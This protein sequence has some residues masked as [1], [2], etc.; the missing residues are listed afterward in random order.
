[1]HSP[2][3]DRERSRRLARAT[4]LARRVS[5]PNV[6][7]LTQEPPA[8][9][10]L[11]ERIRRHGPLS[12]DEARKLA[13]Q[14]CAGLA[15]AH[16]RG[17]AHGKLSVDSIR[18]TDGVAVITDLGMEQ[19]RRGRIDEREDVYALGA[20]LYEALTGEPPFS[21]PVEALPAAV[22]APILRCLQRDPRRRYGTV[23]EAASAL[24][25][26]LAPSQ[27]S[28]AP[29]RG[30]ALAGTLALALLGV[31]AYA[32]WSRS[33]PGLPAARPG[34]EVTATLR[35]REERIVVALAGFD[36][37]ALPP[38]R[39]WIARG[40]EEW[41]AAALLATPSVEP[42]RGTLDRA[43][44]AA[45]ARRAGVDV[46]VDGA[47]APR[48]GGEGG[49][50]LEL[51]LLDVG[52]GALRLAE[53]V[54]IAGEGDL[55]K[56]ARALYEK[57]SRAIR[58]P[59]ASSATVP[60]TGMT[61]DIAALRAYAEARM[62]EERGDLAAAERGLRAA[63]AADPA[64][65]R[66]RAS[67][68]D[69]LRAVG[70][71]EEA[72]RLAEESRSFAASAGE[73]G[74]LTIARLTARS[75][76]ARVR[77]LEALAAR[78][79]RETA[80]ARELVAAL[81]E[82]GR[83]ADC[84]V[85]A[86]RAFEANPAASWALAEAARCSLDVG[87]VDAALGYARRLLS[88]RQ[89]ESRAN[90][91]R[92]GRSEVP[93][94]IFL[95]LGR[96]GDAYDLLRRDADAGDALASARLALVALH[97]RGRC[98]AALGLLRKASARVVDRPSAEWLARA[99]SFAATSCAD[100]GE[101]R[102]AEAWLRRVA[103]MSPV[104]AELAL[105]AA[106]ARGERG[107]FERARAVAAAERATHDGPGRARRL[108]PLLAAARAEGKAREALA[109]VGPPLPGDR[110][111]G[112]E[113][114]LLYEIA[115]A[116]LEAGDVE[117]AGLACAELLGAVPSW[118]PGHYCAGRVAEAGERWSEAFQ[119]YRAFLDRWSDADEEHRLVADARR[120][121]PR[122]VARARAARAAHAP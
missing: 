64:F 75:A 7:P 117:E 76:E 25:V 55:L 63:M 67:L 85:A 84:V 72:A 19:A 79:P 65:F 119:A 4:R 36:A 44:L 77:A 111:A 46:V 97:G 22:R 54:E 114:A 13:R 116:R 37:A 1:M 69:L 29:R 27:A 42:S 100:G 35:P 24:E 86:R 3:S 89:Q 78:Y 73:W 23:A 30:V 6:W 12:L 91:E 94:E 61:A 80:S 34:E 41:F 81:R 32:A 107:A 33:E 51:K 18:L 112:V 60:V 47:V 9:E 109:L 52:S 68:C 17:V 70:Q 53:R 62:A 104:L 14:L 28:P 57:A 83:P 5:H 21:A 10:T 26:P 48:A 2:A 71:D 50:W 101:A 8:A 90:E 110:Y 16:A 115:L 120:R 106:A 103:P 102:D 31:A 58:P 43:A 49:L 98:R 15:A 66:A 40:L 38:E 56:G 39:A 99:W 96:Y 74:A 113:M 95:R 87:D 92:G 59:D 82:A 108:G 93:A 88:A 118:A 45:S 122:V 20:V 105:R 121:L 11:A